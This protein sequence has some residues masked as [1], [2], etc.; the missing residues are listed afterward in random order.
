MHTKT[1]TAVSVLGGA[2][3]GYAVVLAGAPAFVGYITFAVVS[4][5]L[6]CDGS[7]SRIIRR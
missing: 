3:V 7:L 2:A 4:Q 6:M 5:Q 1:E